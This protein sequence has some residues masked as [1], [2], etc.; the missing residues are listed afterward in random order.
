MVAGNKDVRAARNDGKHN[1]GNHKPG[2]FFMPTVIGRAGKAVFILR[3]HGRTRLKY[4]K[5]PS[6]N[7]ESTPSSSR[8]GLIR[9]RSASLRGRIGSSTMRRSMSV[10]LCPVSCSR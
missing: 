3:N 5:A 2:A 6:E 4:K 8:V 7:A 10:R 9:K 1:D